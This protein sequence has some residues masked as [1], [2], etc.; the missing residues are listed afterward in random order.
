MPVDTC[1]QVEELLVSVRRVADALERALIPYQVVG[2]FAIFLHTEPIEPG[3]AHI[4]RKVEIAIDERCLERLAAALREAGFGFQDIGDRTISV[5]DEAGGCIKIH[6]CAWAESTLPVRAMRGLFVM[7]AGG[8]IH[9]ML[10]RYRLEDRLLLQDLDHARIIT[11]EIE[12]SLS[13]PLRAR[14]AEVRA[15]E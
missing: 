10:D 6:T 13:E 9:A 7:P 3:T 12:A 5:P 14:L 15:T 2:S 11:S 4:T 8:L 1:F